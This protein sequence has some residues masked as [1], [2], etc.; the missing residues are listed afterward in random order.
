MDF[1]SFDIADIQRIT[2]AP[3]GEMFMGSVS[4]GLREQLGDNREIIHRIK[5]TLRV[6][7]EANA[8]YESL[9]RIL[10]ERARLLL[11]QANGF[12]QKETVESL[13]QRGRAGAP[14]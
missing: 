13:R 1:E 4:F 8:T 5:M 10:F 9:E 11:G 3:D 12:C 6:K 2:P 14:R 7:T